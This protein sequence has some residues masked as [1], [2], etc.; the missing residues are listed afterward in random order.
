MLGGQR[1]A[2]SITRGQQFRFPPSML[3][4]DWS[5]R[6]NDVSCREFTGSCD[7]SLSGR[8]SLGMSCAPD[9]ATG[10][11]DIRSTYAMYGTVNPCAAHQ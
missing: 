3:A 10:F 6:V 2:V 1:E 5:N 4:E 9:L 11:D 7:Y 8:Q